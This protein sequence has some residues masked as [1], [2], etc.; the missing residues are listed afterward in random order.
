MIFVHSLIML[1]ASGVGYFLFETAYQKG[2]LFTLVL[3]CFWV[4]AAWILWI[5][6]LTHFRRKKIRL[7]Q[8]VD[9]FHES[10]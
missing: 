4:A 5:Q 6:S 10:T 3:A 1:Y 2:K 9:E 7:K 8:V